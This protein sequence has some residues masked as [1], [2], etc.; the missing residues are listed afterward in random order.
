[1]SIAWEKEVET[2]EF[3][4]NLA[5]NNKI[6]LAVS[7]LQKGV[8][9][10]FLELPTEHDK[11]LLADF[12]IDSIKRENLTL[13]TKRTYV[14]GLV[15]L[16]RYFGNKK[17]FEE[18][19]N[20]DL[21]NYINSYQKEWAQDP[22]RSWIS[23]QR[24]SGW[25]LL[26]FYKWHAYPK[27]T[28]QERKLLSGDKLPAVLQGIVL[29]RK[30][31]SKTPV[32]QKDIWDE[33]DTAIFLKYCTD[34]PRLR[35]YHALA[36]ETSAR[37]SELLQLKIG[38]IEIQTDDNGKLCALID[39]GRYGKKKQSRIV[40]ITEFTIQ[41][42]Q[43]YLSSSYHP[44]PE[45]RKAFLFA[46]TEH[47][48]MSRNIQLSGDALRSDYKAFRDRKLPKLLKRSDIPEEDKKHLQFLKETKKWFPYIVRHSSLS[49][50]APNISEYR[51]REHAGWSKRS[52]M[53]EIYTH[54]L[55][56]DS[57]EDILMLYGVNL[58]GGKK[59]RNE[60]LQQEMVGPH[61]PF[62]HM[63][64]TPDSQF[65]SS[66]HKPLTSVSYNK[67][68]Q[69]A[70]RTKGELEQMRQEQRK[71]MNNLKLIMPMLQNV[72]TKLRIENIEMRQA[73]QEA[74]E[75]L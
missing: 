8:Q 19:T 31:G 68:M 12:I 6:K 47:S 22:D 58:K 29:Q 34:N 2:L 59:K 18:F 36:Y 75:E 44:D 14:I 71:I 9:R 45:N 42:Y 73:L 37:P 38:D 53:V 30:K 4:P 55:T 1:M 39:V 43:S 63:V 15:Y 41:Y 27:L 10:L 25:P 33:K 62:C 11:E 16:S 21:A 74:G 20:T 28:P 50:L 24:T 72:T 51:L 35:F 7:G 56:G 66:C 67:I 23:T 61:C 17:S 64:N 40:G 49:R 60:R 46:S 57:A 54:T 5:L 13:A 52:D 69:E 26:K 48:A 70:E 32:K 65:C 3:S